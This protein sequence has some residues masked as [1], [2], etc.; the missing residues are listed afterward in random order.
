MGPDLDKI[1]EELQEAV[2][3]GY[4][5]KLKDEF[6]NPRNIGRIEN[7]DSHA[8]ITGFCGDTVEMYLSILDGKIND[9]KFITD[10][11]GVTIACTSYV[12]R[13]AKGKLLK[14]ALRIKPEDVDNYFD[15]LPEEN[16]HCAKLAVTTL[17]AALKAFV[18]MNS[19]K[20]MSD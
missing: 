19:D 1:A 11:C 9:I 15:G 18:K 14:E 10:G 8:S 12:T 2:L 6:L 17:A 16:K 7:P 4:P 20:Q 5:E 3:E 13:I